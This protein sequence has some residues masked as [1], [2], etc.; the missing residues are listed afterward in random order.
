MS[1]YYK[2]TDMDTLVK[3]EG[4]VAFIFD[5]SANEWVRDM[6]NILGDRFTEQDGEE[7][8]DCVS[9]SE[10]EARAWIARKADGAE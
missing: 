10:N 8:S 5:G 9:I 6:N 7:T 4:D 3:K 2:L 1:E